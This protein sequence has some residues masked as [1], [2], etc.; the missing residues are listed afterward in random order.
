MRRALDL[1][2]FL[3]ALVGC[4]EV[5]APEPLITSIDHVEAGGELV[6]GEAW[7]ARWRERLDAKWRACRLA[8]AAR[9]ELDAHLEWLDGHNAGAT[10]RFV[11]ALE[12]LASGVADE[13]R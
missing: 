10:A 2:V 13:R 12:T 3:L 9:V 8:P 4:G 6:D 1:L 7:L 11:G 5:K